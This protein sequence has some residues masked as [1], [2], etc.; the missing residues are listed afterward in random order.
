L[1]KLPALLIIVPAFCAAPERPSRE[2]LT[3]GG[4]AARTGWNRGETSLSKKNVAGLVLKWKAQIEKSVPVAAQTGASILSAPLTV[5]AVTTPKG[6]RTLTFALSALDTLTA[7]DTNTGSIVWQRKFNDKVQPA[8]QATWL[9]TN[10]VTATPVIDKAKGIV[11]LLT[12][13]GVLHGAS[14]ADGEDRIAPVDFTPPF[15]RNWSLNLI[16]G[17]LYTTVGRGC[18]GA[19]ASPVVS[20]M[21]AMDLNDPARPITRFETSSGRPGGAWGRGGMVW[22]FNSLFTQTA[23]GPWDPAN[24][25]WGETLLRLAPKTLQLQDYF[26]PSNFSELN[27]KD[28]D[29]GSGGPLTFAWEGRDL[30]AAAGKAATVYL[31]DARMLGGEDH[32]TPLFSLKIGNDAESY[33]SNGV[34]GAM[35]TMVDSKNNRRIYV[36]M[37]GPP[38]KEGPGFQSAHGDAPN[39]SIMA[40]RLSMENQKPV[41]VPMW[42][43]RDL[44]VPDPPVVVNGLVLA[45]STGENTIQ[46]HRDARFQALYGNPGEP[47]LTTLGSLTPEERSQHTTHATLYAFDAETGKELY[48]SGDAIDDWTHLSSVTVADGKVFV[49]TRNANI[50]AFGRR[51]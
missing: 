26:T 3:W 45:T 34:W 6:T 4:D 10:T 36:P 23:D 38:S 49:T 50:Y 18:G 44:S 30:V 24:G 43:S 25:R 32:H 19:P 28:L 51:K 40:F 5:E 8:R 48:S 9:C 41:L 27:A 21:L 46:N 12:S 16:D 20:A 15:S 14:L 33:A 29:F 17:V 7:L 2:W 47:P 35:A 13:D 39:G 42:I 31:L 1:K 22:G 11:Y 37:W